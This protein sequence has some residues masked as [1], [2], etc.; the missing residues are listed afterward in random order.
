MAQLTGH[1]HDEAPSQIRIFSLNCWGLKYISKYRQ[2]RLSE[3]GR[4]LA[5]ANPP[6]EIVGLQECWTQEDYESIRKQTQHILP[7][8]KFYFGGIFGA[9]LAILSRW[10]IE[11]SGMYGYPLNGRPTA[12][13]RGDWFVG[14]GVACAR[15]RFGPGVG[16]VA[17]VFCTHLH[18]PYERE[19]HDSYLCHRTAQAWEISKL[20]R[21]AA[22]RGHLVIGLGDFNM[23]PSSFAHRL[24][25]AQSPVRDVWRELHPDSSVG[26]AIDAVERARNR[27]I[28]SAEYNLLENGAT[29]DGSFNTW[30]WS[31]ALRKQLDK[32]QH[33]TIDKDT[34]DPRAK[35]L[36]YIFVG[37]GGYAP[38]FPSPRWSVESA[39]VGMTQRHP[40]LGCSLSDHFAVEAVIT[41]APGQATASTRTCSEPGSPSSPSLH[42]T[43]SKQVSPNAALAPETYD[44]IIDMIHTYVR[45]ERS[46][47]SWRL[48]HFIVSILISIGCMV[49]VWWIGSR[50]YIGFI[51]ILVS[52]LNFGAG[53]LDG[54]IGGLFVSSEL[55][56][57]KEFEWEV[58]NARGLVLVSEDIGSG[59][60]QSDNQMPSS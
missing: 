54:L 18:A 22:E 20:M 23:L 29:C 25:T 4:Q 11:E 43:S 19:P 38:E 2:E 31:E 48:I 51:L 52:T 10:P 7:Y 5:L 50:T 37:D 39:T 3:I 16:D 26:A 49:G 53:I 30:R 44:H 36:D 33:V 28:P 56:A 13:F 35:R 34:P 46:Q 15:I 24:I 45:R 59:E 47:R 12:F 40:T 55:R 1:D 6:P 27:P 42:K 32:G 9:G 21:G 58:R 14:K 60:R 17:E 41:R 57:L 8:G